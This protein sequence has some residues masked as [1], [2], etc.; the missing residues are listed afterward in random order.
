MRELAVDARRADIRPG[1][2]VADRREVRAGRGLGQGVAP[3]LL[4]TILKQPMHVGMLLRLHQGHQERLRSQQQRRQ[5]E[6]ALIRLPLDTGAAGQPGLHP[7]CGVQQLGQHPVVRRV[8]RLEPPHLSQAAEHGADD[9]RRLVLRVL[10]LAA[11]RLGQ[12]RGA[13]LQVDHVVAE[14]FPGGELGLGHA[15]AAAAELVQG[16][17]GKKGRVLE[18]LHEHRH[19]VRQIAQRGDVG[20]DTP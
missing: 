7:P 9:T 2:G 12:R 14:T 19:A 13:V 16:H 10:D 17:A 8:H 15:R 3:D 20:A 4:V 5:V 11:A 1:G 18:V 6:G